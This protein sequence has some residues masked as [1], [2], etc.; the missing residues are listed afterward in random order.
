MRNMSTACPLRTRRGD[1]PVMAFPC[2]QKRW[3]TG[4]CSVQ[5]DICSRPT[6]LWGK[7]SSKAGM[8]MG[9]RQGCRPS[10]SRARRARPRTGCG[11][12]S[13]MGTAAP[14]GWCSS[15]MEG[16]GADTAWWNSSGKGSMGIPPVTDTRHTTACQGK[17]TRSVR[18]RQSRF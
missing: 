18:S 6:S 17:D 12:A 3:R 2:Q 14:P 4:W 5:A 1:S 10:M 11:C 9:M 15:S 16:S 8:Y 7:D 13:R